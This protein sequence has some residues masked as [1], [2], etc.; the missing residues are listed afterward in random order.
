MSV[1]IPLGA[2]PLNRDDYDAVV[3]GG[4][5]VTFD[6]HDIVARTRATI[7]ARVERGEPV[8]AANT[9]Y[10][11][12]S[13]RAVE[14]EAIDEVQMNTI[15]S[16]AVGVGTVVPDHIVRGMLLIKAQAFAQGAAGVRPALVMR[17]AE[18][19]NGRI[20]P[21][22]RSQGSQSASGDLIPNAQL[23]LAV[24]GEGQVSRN[25]VRLPTRDVLA[26][27]AAEAKE[28][29]A[30]T[31][32]VAF[33]TAT[34][35]DVIRAVDH[36]IGTAEQTA[37]MALNAVRGCSQAFDQRLIALRPHPDA[38]ATASHMRALLAG[39]SLVDSSA[40]LHD[41][42]AFRCIP[43]VHGA[44][45]DALGHAR[46]A[47]EVEIRSV[48][49]NPVVVDSDVLSGGNFHGA[50]IALTMDA[51]NTALTTLAALSQR[52]T[53]LLVTGFA[54][55]PPGLAPDPATQIGTKMLNTAGASLVSES[56]TLCFPASVT[57]I[58][59]D[60]VED[61]VS[62][63]SVAA[64]K[65][66]H[67]LEMVRRVVLIETLCAAQALDLVGAE[68]ASPAVRQ[69]HGRV[70]ERVP[71]QNQDVPVDLEALMTVME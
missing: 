9:G 18:M 20:H 11:A 15:R 13:G 16:H 37:A 12:D 70:R 67:N 43:Q 40:R 39:G 55:L 66:A 29:V 14:P 35:W 59:I 54:G 46:D 53:H 21:V 23:A 34:S 62:M 6:R 10:G 45:R 32:D 48:G 57:S 60:E 28:G 44:A 7:M 64:R 36:L 42:Y 1:P 33:A 5:A 24:I 8:Y 69:V 71:F 51:L 25:G 4:A 22:V 68:Y 2:T 3:Y 50:P 47:V 38:A 41:P 63:A 26:P 52:R 31:N 19:L 30:L 58:G 17:L 65:A 61:H 49:D 27:F 56:M